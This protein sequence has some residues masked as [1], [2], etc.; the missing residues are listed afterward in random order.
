MTY[1]LSKIEIY[2]NFNRKLYCKKGTKLKEIAR[3]GEVIIVQ[4]E[5][6]EPFPVHQ[7][8]IQRIN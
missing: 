2:S 5:K 4:E 3:H 7:S 1:Y 8:K 6:G